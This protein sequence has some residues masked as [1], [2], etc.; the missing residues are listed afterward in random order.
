M[1]QVR[2]KKCL[3]P[4]M[5]R[6]TRYHLFFGCLLH[7]LL[8]VN[9]WMDFCYLEMSESSHMNYFDTTCLWNGNQDRLA[10]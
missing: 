4:Q 1:R 8:C 7:D 3:A 6:L 9:V 5:C 10:G 2:K